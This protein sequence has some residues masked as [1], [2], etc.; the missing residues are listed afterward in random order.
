MTRGPC[1]KAVLSLGLALLLIGFGHAAAQAQVK[2]VKPA[3]GGTIKIAKP[4]S[5][6]LAGNLSSGLFATPAIK[7]TANNVTI[8]LNGFSIIGPGG[9]GTA[10]AINATNASGVTIVNG[11]ITRIA[12][13]AILLGSNST[14]GGVQVIGNSGDGIDCTSSCLVTNNIVSG[15]AGTGLGFG[16]SSSGYQNNIVTGN[17]TN[18][19]GGTNLG[20]NVCN[21]ALCP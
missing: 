7:V 12:G 9:N 16:D 5:Y 11:T 2:L 14:V 10:S 6:F 1:G 17:G 21:G 19:T 20:H 3:S 15:N 8:N 13:N 18:I 4:G